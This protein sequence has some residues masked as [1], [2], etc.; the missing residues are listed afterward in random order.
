MAYDKST[1]QVI[2]FG[3]RQTTQRSETWAWTP[4]SGWKRLTPATNPPGR[5]WGNMAYDDAAGQIVLF[6]GQSAIPVSG[7]L[8]LLADTWTWD[9]T[10]WTHRAPAQ[11]PPPTIFMS[12]A[13]D[14]GTQTLIA[15]RDN[16]PVQTTATW[17]WN[18]TTW[19]RLQTTRQPIWPKQ[20]DGIAYATA[21]AD[22]TVFG[23][24]YGLGVTPESNT[25]TYSANKWTAHGASASTPKP[26]S[27][28]GMSEDTRGGVLMFGGG[29][30]GFT[31]YGDTWTYYQHAWHKLSVT[32]APHA[33]TMPKMAYDSTCGIVLL[34]GG[35]LSTGQQVTN[36]RDTWVWDG[37]TWTKVG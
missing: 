26:R 15:V 17:Q 16:D 24:I 28:P 10:D 19:R 29:G 9:G 36:Y 30:S 31:V 12:M 7:A 33:R 13:Y 4:A 14:A 34:Y 37:Q 1:E 6:G 25:W 21:T 32:P 20:G 2:L 18:G 5:T 35:E 3:V 23:T 22:M 8:D 11:S 27:F